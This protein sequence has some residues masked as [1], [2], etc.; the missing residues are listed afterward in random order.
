MA[1]AIPACFLHTYRS[2][3]PC[4]SSRCCTRES[5]TTGSSNTS[6]P[7]AVYM[8]A[9]KRH[10]KADKTIDSDARTVRRVALANAGAAILPASPE[11]MRDE[12]FSLP[13]D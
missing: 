7:G 1:A 12:D 8:A 11:R 5:N 10:G 2:M 13:T 4:R 6:A 9:L 3:I